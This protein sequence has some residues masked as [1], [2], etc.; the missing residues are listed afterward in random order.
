MAVGPRLVGVFFS[1]FFAFR[2]RFPYWFFLF[3]CLLFGF[4]ASLHLLSFF[5]IPDDD[6]FIYRSISSSCIGFSGL[7]YDVAFLDRSGHGFWHRWSG[8]RGLSFLWF[9]GLFFL[10]G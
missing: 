3:P 9:R 4:F 1:L 8:L 2:F 10:H 6:S 5:V 7:H